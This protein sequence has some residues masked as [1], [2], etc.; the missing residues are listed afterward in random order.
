MWPP[1]DHADDDDWL[2]E[3]RLTEKTIRINSQ[4]LTMMDLEQADDD[5]EFNCK[6]LTPAGRLS[7]AL[8]FEPD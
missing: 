1:E 3:K 6:Y 5:D 2:D 7:Q 4:D 8:T